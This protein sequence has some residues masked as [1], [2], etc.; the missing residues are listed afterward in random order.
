MTASEAFDKIIDCVKIS[1]LNFCLQLSPFSA[2]IYLK[3]TPIKD[4][5]G[6]DLNPVVSDP[7]L[8]QKYILEN[9]ELSKN[10][11]ALEDVI[12]DFRQHLKKSEKD[13]E[14][15][16]ETISEMK[17][18]LRIKKENLQTKENE[19]E[20]NFL[21]QLE[22]KRVEISLFCDEKK[23]L[24]SEH[25]EKV[26]TLQTRLQITENSVKRLN[27]A[28]SENRINADN[29]T[30]Q[31]RKSFKT[32]IKSWKKE[33][34]HE[35]S[36]RIKAERELDILENH[37]KELESSSQES[38][39]CQTDQTSDVPFL[40]S[41]PLPP[42]FGSQLCKISKT[43]NHLSS[44]LPDLSTLTWVKFTEEEIIADEA[45]Q[46]LNAQHDREV[47]DFYKEAKKTA[48]NLRGIFEENCIWRLFETD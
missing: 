17:N 20:K 15:A 31:I 29:K 35:R 21:D 5:S 10:V 38:T 16:Q 34:G 32:E 25:E 27:K 12:N 13:R 33:L 30:K 46:A 41:E 4:K 1:N 39:A 8:L 47:S 44:S 48:E 7:S 18:K 43:I 24:E 45:E 2:N 40:I 6:N 11:A 9:A 14:D 36:K 42:I 19:L 37:L 28:V 26:R 23:K 3:K 22:Q